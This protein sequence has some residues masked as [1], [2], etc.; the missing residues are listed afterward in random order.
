MYDLNLGESLHVYELEILR[1][2][3]GWLFIHFFDPNPTTVFV[4][5]SNE[6]MKSAL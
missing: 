1:V 4:P 5:F 6:F 3:G 2:P